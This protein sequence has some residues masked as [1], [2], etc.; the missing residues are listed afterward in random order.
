MKNRIAQKILLGTLFSLLPLAT[1]AQDAGS[2]ASWWEAN[3]Q[4]VLVW[5]VLALEVLLL[6]VVLTLYIVIRM[7]A[8][9]VLVPEPEVVEI[10]G[11]KKIVLEPK[12]TFVARVMHQ[13][14]DSVPVAQEEE[15]MTDH[16]YDGIYELDNNL[17]PWWKAM[18][19]VTIVFGVVY[20]LNYH[21]FDTGDLQGAEYEKEMAAAQA[22]IEAF[23]ATQENSVDETN[24]TMIED[25]TRLASGQSMYMQKCSP[26]HGAE[27]G[28]GVGPN[29]T[30][31]Y[32]IHGGDIKDIYKTIK[33]GIPAKGMIPWESQLSPAQMQDISSYIITLEGTDPP[34]PKEPEGELYERESS[35]ALAK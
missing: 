5:S 9:R 7:I 32:W 16:E 10:S 31:Q 15:V 25:D 24:V 20:L 19:Y 13:L 2:S 17:P 28:G 30:D 29:L 1:I 23:L 33:Y 27:G 11:D 34:N 18:F 8:N 35:V 14:T 21:V 6:L 12:E 22:E 4:E 3:A 26:C